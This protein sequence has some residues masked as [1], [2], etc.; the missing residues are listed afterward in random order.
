MYTIATLKDL[1]RQLQLA[2]SAADADA[3]LL[4]ALTE[5]SHLLE[6]LTQRRYC[7]HFESR[8]ISPEAANPR[9]LF[10]PGD[11][12]ELRGIRDASGALDLAHIR[13][14]PRNP[15]APA[16]M[17]QR[18]DGAPFRSGASGKAEI[19]V[20]GIWGWHDRWRS[21]WRDSR[22]TLRDT[23]L[24]AWATTITVQAVNGADQDGMKPRF[25]IGQLLRVKDEYLR[26]TALDA[27]ARQVTVLRG[28]N[29][30]RAASH[31][32]GSKIA[33]YAP[34]AA[35]RDLTVRYAALMAQS[36]GK[37]EQQTSPLLQQIRRLS[38]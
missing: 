32:R 31:A 29:G 11:L 34:P 8:L 2:D 16:Y 10:L 20:D 13:R 38:V 25:Q 1:R 22:D 9:E 14:R 12:L 15:D 23:A 18:H 6:S 17:L 7:P 26:V 37:L 27:A 4:R 33:S 21:A 3:D 36:I 24:T 28:V 35:I 5:A 30:S 19:R